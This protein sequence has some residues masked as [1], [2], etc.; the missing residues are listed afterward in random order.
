MEYIEIE[1]SQ[2]PY[3]FDIS[4]SEEIFTFEIQYNS[5]YDFFTVDLEQ[6]GEVIVYGEKIVYG[7]PLFEDVKDGRFPQV[8]IIP[9]DESGINTEVIFKTLNDSVFLY[10]LEVDEDV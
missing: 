1:K 8:Q 3:R 7:I 9:Y 4:L 5:E 2:V 10:V 6:N